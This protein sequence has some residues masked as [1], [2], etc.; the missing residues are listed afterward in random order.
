MM[1]LQNICKSYNSKPVLR[2]VTLTVTSGI[3]CLMGLSGSGKTTLLRIL[4]GLEKPDAG[5]LIDIPERFA[6]LFQED[7]LVETLT[8][9]ANLRA[10]LGKAW[11]EKEAEDCLIKL[12]LPD[13]LP[14]TVSSLSGGMKR[15]VA[16]A[17][18]LLYDAPLKGLDPETRALAIASVRE[19]AVRRPVLAVI[20][21]EE[22]CTLLNGQIVRLNDL[23]ED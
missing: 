15:R 10:A 12:G 19:Q 11:N 5:K 2:G 18:A 22:E 20:H 7:R 21:D 6:V 14:E 4:L 1:T 3:T 13:V 9:R 17:R 16:L 23:Q 8:V